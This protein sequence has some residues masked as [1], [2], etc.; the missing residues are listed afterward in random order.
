M[1]W[2]PELSDTELK[3]G[4]SDDEQAKDT[5]QKSKGEI[6]KN[7]KQA[8]N[9]WEKV[10]YF[11]LVPDFSVPVQALYGSVLFWSMGFPIVCLQ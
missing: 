6:S 3:Q 4:K 11:Y 5:S 1:L 7:K 2:E 9:H 10:G 8:C